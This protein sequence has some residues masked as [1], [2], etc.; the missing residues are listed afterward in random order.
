MSRSK[1]INLLAHLK[2]EINVVKS[3]IEP[4]TSKSY[5]GIYLYLEGRIKEIQ[6]EL[7]LELSEIDEP[8]W[9]VGKGGEKINDE[10]IDAYDG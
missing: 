6:K 1:R 2:E 7:D 8:D 4:H 3:R 9:A 5:H 10:P